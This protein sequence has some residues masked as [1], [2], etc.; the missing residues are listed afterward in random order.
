VFGERHLRHVLES[1]MNYYNAGKNVAV[2]KKRFA[3]SV[4]PAYA[5]QLGPVVRSNL[6]GVSADA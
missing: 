6:A 2:F 4:R 5:A 1:Y 3:F